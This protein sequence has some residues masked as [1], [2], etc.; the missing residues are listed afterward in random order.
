MAKRKTRPKTGVKSLKLPAVLAYLVAGCGVIVIIVF[1]G[2]LLVGSF[3]GS[4]KEE[5]KSSP[6]TA[7][8]IQRVGEWKTSGT[9]IE[10]SKD[11]NEDGMAVVNREKWDKLP[12]DSK[13]ALAIAVSRANDIKTLQVKDETG[14]PLGICRY[15]VRLRENK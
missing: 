7:V 10:F 1:I 9:L 5:K 3:A 15:G 12:F 14:A 11:K 4:A 6:E 13:E 8:W 2:Y